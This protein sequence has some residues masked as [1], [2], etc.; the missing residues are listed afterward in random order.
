MKHE[1]IFIKKELNFW[2]RILFK[3][4]KKTFVKIYKIGI[5]FGFNNK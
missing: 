1:I 4:F 5:T 2:E 3:V